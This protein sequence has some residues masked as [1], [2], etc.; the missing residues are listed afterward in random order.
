MHISTLI[1]FQNFLCLRLRGAREIESG[2]LICS[3][4][5]S[6]S[7]SFLPMYLQKVYK[8]HITF[9]H[10]WLRTHTHSFFANFNY[11][12]LL[13]EVKHK[14]EVVCVEII[15]YHRNCPRYFVKIRSTITLNYLD[16]VCCWDSVGNMNVFITFKLQA[17]S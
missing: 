15:L 8:L 3:N 9:N 13:E 11:R 5:L 16:L 6:I 12:G 7:S 1:P 2:I 10:V 17:N 14:K 4:R